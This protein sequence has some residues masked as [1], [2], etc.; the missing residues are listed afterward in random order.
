MDDAKRAFIDALKAADR[1]HELLPEELVP[2]LPPIYATDG[3]PDDERVAHVKFFCPV[4]RW[5]WY[6]IEYDPAD[7]QFF[8]YVVSGLGPDCD[9]LTYW[10]LD[11]LEELGG[12]VE[13]D[14]HWQPSTI[15]EV[16]REHA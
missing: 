13:R 10:S 6:G 2:S 9:E 1:G 8:G 3:L 14:L 12:L 15:A 7:R 11:Q 5:T 4:G 16:K